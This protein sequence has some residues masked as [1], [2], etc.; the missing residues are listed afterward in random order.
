MLKPEPEKTELMTTEPIFV[1]V[2]PAGP[3]VQGVYTTTEGAAIGAR[4]TIETDSIEHGDT[5][6]I[7]ASRIYDTVGAH[8]MHY[9][10]KA[11]Q[12]GKTLEDLEEESKEENEV[13]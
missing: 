13:E 10:H 6:S 1:V 4:M 8:N 12:D 11:Q 9:L 3:F 7:I 2:D 5:V